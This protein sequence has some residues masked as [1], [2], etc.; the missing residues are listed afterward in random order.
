MMAR[1]KLDEDSLVR[2]TSKELGIDEQTLRRFIE[3]NQVDP[4]AFYKEKRQL[5]ERAAA[6]GR[7][8]VLGGATGVV[9]DFRIYAREDPS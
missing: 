8:N 3:R 4:V 1:A 5:M 6:H 9:R 2:D 7:R